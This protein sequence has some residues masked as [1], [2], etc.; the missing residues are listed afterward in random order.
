MASKNSRSGSRTS[1]RHKVLNFV[2]IVIIM[3]T[4]NFHTF[5]VGGFL[6]GAEVSLRSAE[7]FARPHCVLN[8]GFLRGAEVFG[9]PHRVLS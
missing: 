9:R 5:H 3:I 4:V 6:G 2:I 7:V 1:G 8:A